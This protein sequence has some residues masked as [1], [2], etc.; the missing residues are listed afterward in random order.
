M[1]LPYPEYKFTNEDAENHLARLV[2][3]DNPKIYPFDEYHSHEYN[4]LLYF[5]EGGGL[6]NIEFKE[7]KIKSKSIH[8]LAAGSLHWLERGMKSKG[9]AIVYKDQ[10]LQKLQQYHEQFDFVA[11]FSTSQVINFNKKETIEFDFLIQ[12]LIRNITNASYVL[13]L[14]GSF[15]T[16]IAM[17]FLLHENTATKNKS[18]DSLMID[19]VKL[20]NLHYKEHLSTA[21]YAQKLYLSLS[22]LQRKSKDYTGK[23]I[24]ALQQERLLKEAKRLLTFPEV[25]IKDVAYDLGFNEVAHFSNW[26][27][28]YANTTPAK[29]INELT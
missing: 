23:S 10:F 21:E 28:K 2:R 6:H 7:F 15:L 1:I 14:I 27:K 12:E 16:K 29:Y 22:T 3:L 11:L 26:F 9:F 13:S 25:T 17:L 24:A 5:E 8:L 18:T 4:E 19:V 20:I